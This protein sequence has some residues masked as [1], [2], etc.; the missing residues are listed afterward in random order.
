MMLEK[1]LQAIEDVESRDHVIDEF[2]NELNEFI[3]K[4]QSEGFLQ[5]VDLVVRDRGLP[6]STQVN[7]V[8]L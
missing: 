7:H 8:D 5:S 6:S 1:R 3:E 2:M 4:M